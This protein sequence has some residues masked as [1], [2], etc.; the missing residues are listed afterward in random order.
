MGRIVKMIPVTRTTAVLWAWKN[1]HELGRWAGFAWRALTP[2]GESRED[3]VAEARLRAALARDERTRGLRTLVVRV[4]GATATLDGRMSPPL[5]DLV[6]SFA[7][8]TRGVLSVE[9]RIQ[10][11]RAMGP[12]RAHIHTEQGSVPRRADLPG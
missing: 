11:R 2:G 10:D 5:H 7:D 8:G 12:P 3:V 9:C 6:Y 4:A 1:R